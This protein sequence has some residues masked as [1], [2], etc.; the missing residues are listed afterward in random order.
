MS[1]TKALLKT[2]AGKIGYEI[3]RTPEPPRWPKPTPQPPADQDSGWTGPIMQLSNRH[4]R[5]AKLE[6]YRPVLGD[7]ERLKYIIHF[8]D[9]RELRVLEIGPYQGKMSIILEK[10]GVRETVSIESRDGNLERCKNIKN[11]Y[12]LERTAF[13]KHDLE[14]LAAHEEQ[15]QFAGPFDLVFCLGVLYHL[16]DPVEA[17]MWMRQQSETL[18]LGTHYIEP[19]TGPAAFYTHNGKNYWGKWHDEDINNRIHGM[20]PQAFEP[21]EKDLLAMLR[22]AGYAEISVLGRDLHNGTPHITILAEARSF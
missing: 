20:S 22:D 6:Y 3:R 1:A 7:D 9:V 19:E 4:Y 18:F 17:L 21:Y 15:A 2:V 11:R 13:L 14:R 16:V 5:P 10:M 8:L 12:Q